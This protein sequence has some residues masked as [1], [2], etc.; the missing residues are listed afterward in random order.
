MESG[1]GTM[2][3][4]F[5]IGVECSLEK[6]VTARSQHPASCRLRFS[7]EERLAVNCKPIRVVAMDAND[8]PCGLVPWGKQGDGCQLQLEILLL[9]KGHKC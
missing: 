4:Q 7:H 2:T 5:E 6:V 9:Q 8:E 3:T 1:V